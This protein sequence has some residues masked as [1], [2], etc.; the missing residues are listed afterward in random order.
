MLLVSPLYYLAYLRVFIIFTTISTV[1]KQF[2]RDLKDGSTVEDAFAIKFKKPPVPYK[3]GKEGSWF[4]L[5][6]GDKTGELSLKFWGRDEEET[7]SIFASLEKNEIVFIRGRVNEF[8]G[9][10]QISVEPGSGGE[11][12]RMG[13]YDMSDFVSSTPKDIDVMM[14][15]LR[16]RVNEI[17]DPHIKNL[18]DLFLSDTEFV[19]K[20]SHSPAAM[21]RHQNYIGGLLEHILNLIKICDNI[22]DIHTD[23]NRDLLIAGCMFHDIGKI[24]EFEATTSIDV[25]REGMLIGHIAIGQ[26]MVDDKI[27]EIK[28]FP[29]ELRLKIIHMILSHHGRLEYGS[30]KLPQIPEAIALY[31]A[32]EM[33]AKVDYIIRL[34]K[35]ANTQ[36]PW[37]WTKDYGHI[38]LE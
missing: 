33:D 28:D 2:I 23:L 1:K 21:H 13:E 4:S 6:I 12:R 19:E 15:D 18:F 20:F 26:K 27:S 24:V 10:L 16:S 8:N 37:I 31:H 9:K 30:P 36:D 22:A 5:Q 7:D 14:G 3:S 32:D 17:Q 25:S 34:K 11:I 38:Y 29:Q 35:E